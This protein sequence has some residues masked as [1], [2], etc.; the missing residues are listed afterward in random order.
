MRSSGSNLSGKVHTLGDNI[1]TDMLAPGG[2]L[3]MGIEAL[4]MH[5]L[6]AVEPGWPRKVSRG[7]VIIA[8]RNFGC[9]SSREQAAIVLKDLGISLVLA[10]SFARIFY[11]NAVNVGLPLGIIQ[12]EVELKEGEMV[13]YNISKEL[14]KGRQAIHFTGVSGPL[15]EILD[16]GGLVPFVISEISKNG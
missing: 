13:T 1:D 3:H 16:A 4:K 5:C 9:G 11:R 6:E 8:G 14:V 12:G 10:K 15:R 2:Y 7:D